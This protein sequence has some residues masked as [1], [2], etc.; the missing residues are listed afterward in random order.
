MKRFGATMLIVALALPAPASAQGARSGQ[1]PARAAPAAPAKPAEPPPPEPPAPAYE[2]EMLRLSEI[3]G[4]LAFLRS[5]CA[6]PDAGE[7]PTRM[8]ALLESEG[9][10]PGRRE[11]LAGAYNRGYRGYALTYRACTPSATEASARFLKEGETLSRN[12][13]GRYGG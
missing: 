13:A 4:A 6:A 2:K 10:T 5:L 1:A 8:Q 9:G 7:W 3:V 11:R 12:L